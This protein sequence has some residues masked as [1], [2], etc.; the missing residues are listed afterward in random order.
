MPKSKMKSIGFVAGNCPIAFPLPHLC[1]R[2]LATLANLADWA[3][4]AVAG[5]S[6][7]RVGLMQ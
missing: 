4:A 6:I 1:V 5:A 3:V 7:P 2:I